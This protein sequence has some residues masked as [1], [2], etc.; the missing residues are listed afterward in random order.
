M[1]K[2]KRKWKGNRNSKGKAIVILYEA[3]SDTEGELEW[4]DSEPEASHAMTISSDNDTDSTEL[5]CEYN[6]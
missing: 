3:H 1:G 5:D 4:V 2:G 6:S